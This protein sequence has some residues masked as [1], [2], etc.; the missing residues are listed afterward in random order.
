MCWQV[1]SGNPYVVGIELCHATN[2]SDFEAVWNLGVEWAAWA[3]SKFGW[4]TSRLLSHDDCRRI[5]GG[6]DHTDPLDYFESYGKSW[7][8]FK[9]EVQEYLDDGGTEVITDADI[10]AIAE[11]VAPYVW[12]YVLRSGN[13]AA[14]QLLNT[15]KLTS[16]EILGYTNAAM[17]GDDDVYQILTD[18][19]KYSGWD[20]MNTALESGDTYQILRDIRDTVVGLQKDIEELRKNK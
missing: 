16:T 6:T 8:Q 13:S 19:R 17:N 11:K 14:N 5:W 7:E 18:N 3:L 2:Q 4:D 12:G 1:G 20:Y 9:Q 10:T 15:P